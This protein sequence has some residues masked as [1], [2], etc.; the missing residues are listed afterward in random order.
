MTELSFKRFRL[1]ANSK[2][3]SRDWKKQNRNKAFKI[4]NHNNINLGIP[5]GKI[6]NITVID[7]DTNKWNENHIFYKYFTI[8]EI[9][10]SSYSVKSPNGYH[11]YYE[12][13][14]DIYQT[15][16]EEHQIDIR[17]DGGY[18]VSAGS[19]V[20]G[21]YYKVINRKTIIPM[22]EKMKQFLIKYITPPIKINRKKN[23]NNICNDIYRNMININIY[24][25]TPM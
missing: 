23:N 10:E 2:C 1:I 22:P 19:K 6:N 14:E 13:D 12:Y 9:I 20:D 3:P 21:K 15:Q 18:I 8:D 17:G 25:G 11:I 4:Y 24:D 5:T 7:L 16:C